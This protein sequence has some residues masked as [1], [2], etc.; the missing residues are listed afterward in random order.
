MRRQPWEGSAPK[1]ACDACVNLGKTARPQP[2]WQLPAAALLAALH[3]QKALGRLVAR[4]P[5]LLWPPRP[6]VDHSEYKRSLYLECWNKVSGVEPADEP[7]LPTAACTTR[8]HWEG[9]LV[10]CSCGCIPRADSRAS[11]HCSCACG[12]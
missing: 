5:A 12:R 11:I 4:P 10:P 6:A 3:K 8:M 2:Q 1:G 7:G 9:W